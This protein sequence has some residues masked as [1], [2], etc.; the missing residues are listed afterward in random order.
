MMRPS[1]LCQQRLQLDM[2]PLCR[3]QDLLL[4]RYLRCP[5][6]PILERI[7]GSKG[8]G[9]SVETLA[10]MSYCYLQRHSSL[11]R[12]L[13]RSAVEAVGGPKVEV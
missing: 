9:I 8:N 10:R 12:Q 2:F 7:D 11:A 6:D 3:E 4:G 1:Y 13:C 5:G